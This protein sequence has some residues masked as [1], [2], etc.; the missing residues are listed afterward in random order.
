MFNNKDSE[1]K[2]YFAK[3]GAVEWWDKGKPY[4]NERDLFV[5]QYFSRSRNKIRTILDLGAGKGRITIHL[6]VKGF[7][8]IALDISKAMLK[9]AI[10]RTTENDV[11][12]N[13]DFVLADAEKLPFRNK[14]FDALVCIETLMH[15]PSVLSVISE[16][17]RV[18]RLQGVAIADTTILEN[19]IHSDGLRVFLKAWL[20]KHF[21]HLF[22][23]FLRKKII[24]SS[25]KCLKAK[26]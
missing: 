19:L 26:D 2:E 5:L 23:P 3:N 10:K 22:P 11:R 21:Y 24:W 15:V 6:A 12:R 16:I 4:L 7:Q 13:V 1:L 18:I 20:I 17:R 8:V 14:V 25:T 9:M